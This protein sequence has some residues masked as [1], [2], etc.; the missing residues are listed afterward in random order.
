[1]CFK[2]C[3]LGRIISYKKSKCFRRKSLILWQSFAFEIVL[4]VVNFVECT[5]INQLPRLQT[6]GHLEFFRLQKC[7][8]QRWK[9][10][11]NNVKASTKLCSMALYLLMDITDFL[12]CTQV[13]FI[14]MVEHGIKVG[15]CWTETPRPSTRCCQ[16][17]LWDYV[18]LASLPP[19]PQI[20]LQIV[21][22]SLKLM[23]HIYLK[24]LMQ[25]K[26]LK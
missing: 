12:R 5:N 21:D 3:L 15:G 8:I 9:Y 16:T 24:Q 18:A 17:L 20:N 26:L 7:K 2:V 25:N 19:W 13:L 23:P 22:N 14:F 10:S 4:F 1:M 11:L 6:S